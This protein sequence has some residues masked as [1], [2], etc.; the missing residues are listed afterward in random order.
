MKQPARFHRK[1]MA[2]IDSKKRQ[3][4]KEIFGQKVYQDKKEAYLNKKHE[5]KKRAKDSFPQTYNDIS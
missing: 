3:I 2:E 5:P 1:L 4:V